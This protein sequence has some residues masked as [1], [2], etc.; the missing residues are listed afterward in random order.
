M[1][2]PPLRRG[3]RGA[4]ERS[5]H[6]NDAAPLLAPLFALLLALLFAQL[7]ALL[8]AVRIVQPRS[9][10]GLGGWQTACRAACPT[11]LS[12]CSVGLR[13]LAAGGG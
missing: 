13:P 12:R 3:R 4:R 5:V 1:R 10:A 8:P 6:P 7:L 9:S 2:L 11:R